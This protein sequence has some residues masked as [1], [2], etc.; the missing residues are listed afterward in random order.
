M[1]T[2]VEKNP[3]IPILRSFT[4]ADS[5]RLGKWLESPAHNQRDDVRVLFAYLVGGQDRL[6]KTSSLTKMRI[7]KRIFPGES[8]DDA[9]LR[10]TFHWA[11]KA[12]EAF[13]AYD[14][15]C[16]N[17][18]HQQLAL[19][20]ELRRRN[21]AGPAARSLKKAEQLQEV[22]GIKNETHL[23][24]QYLLEL[25]KDEHRIY[26]QLLDKPRF[27]EIADTL[28]YT[29]LIEKLKASWNMLYHQR[30]YKTAF[31]V[32]FLDEVVSYVERINLDEHPVIAI[33]YYGYLGLVEDD[34]SGKTIALL[35][36]AVEK[37][38]DL[39]SPTDLRYVILMAINL[40][41][42]NMNQG[43]EPYIRE[44]FEWYKL[45]FAKDVITENNLLTRATY[46]NVITIVLR[47]KEYAWASQFIEEQSSQLEEDIRENTERFARARLAYEQG[48]YNNSMP[49]LVQVDFKHP[50][51]NLM[52][53]T[54]LLKI[55][56]ELDEFDALDSQ[57][58]SMAT[59]IRRKQLSDLHKNNFSS[60]VRYT[61]QLS[62]TGRGNQKK[63]A[64]LRQ[65]VE[66]T[67]PL[68]EKKWLLEQLDKR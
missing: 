5:R 42:S 51:Y 29:Y 63:L 2:T 22:V 50:V 44:S 53:K 14:Y 34:A 60:I 18:F 39:L 21:I 41:I 49:L 32:K 17:E 6:Y 15:W 43:R 62:R 7:W 55:Y 65:K 1:E 30:V 57:L 19:T 58:D 68:T 59:Y 8:F 64:D 26:Y 47:L 61:R 27:Q 9:R 31:D 25:E 20:K 48:D 36:D 38:G 35:R 33:H 23:R 40:C 16:R 3:L 52:A 24:D 28:D 67:S 45:G 10:Q 37:H 54:L 4:K 12:T 56:F 46:L 13:L 66:A 11:L